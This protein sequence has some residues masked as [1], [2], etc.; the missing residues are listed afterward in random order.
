MPPFGMMSQHSP[1]V[2]SQ[3][4]TSSSAASHVKTSVLQDLEKA[5]LESEA[6]FSQRLSGLQKKLSL[7]LCFLKMY[8]PLELEDFDRSS[9]HLPKWGM[10]VG[11]LVYLPQALEPIT[12]AKDGSYLPTPTA[13]NYGSNKGGA[14]GRIGK[15]RLSLE[16]MARKNMW[17]TPQA[18]SAPDC[19]A[20]RLRNTPSLEAQANESLGV[21]GGQLNPTW[22]EWLMG[23]NLG[24]TESEHWAIQ[25]F[26]SKSKRRL[27][28]YQELEV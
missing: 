5:W 17:P 3:A 14:Q 25:W 2:C 27:K 24:T 13:Q 1:E 28:S 11:G 22:V 6:V 15:E 19:E 21:T 12:S 18:R 20:E 16:S 4:S 10:I 23:Y 26:L 8:L 9:E 7:R